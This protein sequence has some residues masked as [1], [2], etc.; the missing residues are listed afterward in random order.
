M[1]KALKSSQKRHFANFIVL[2][3]IIAVIIFVVFP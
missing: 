2:A 3:I 1:L